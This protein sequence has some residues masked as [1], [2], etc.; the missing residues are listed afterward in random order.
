MRNEPLHRQLLTLVATGIMSLLLPAGNALAWGRDGHR[1]IGDIAERYLEATAARQVRA[2]LALDNVASLADVGS[3][4][5]EYRSTHRQ[6]GPWHYVNIPIVDTGY[7]TSRDC[8]GGNCVVAKIEEFRAVLADKAASPRA[9]LEALKFVVHFIGDEHQPLH[10]A[11]NGDR[12]GNEVKV[13]LGGKNTNL[14][15]VWDSDIIAAT[16]MAEPDFPAKLAG[17]ITDADVKAWQNGSPV[18]WANESYAIAKHVLY[19]CSGSACTPKFT[20]T[21]PPSY[22]AD[23]ALTVRAQLARAGVRLAGLLNTTLH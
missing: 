14:H 8:G 10:C 16:G 18:E 2:L 5:D 11:D 19:T 15:A 6:S 23:N 7:D 1:I 17:T 3:W 21:L 12:G 9:R 4:A 20:G 13:T 22:P